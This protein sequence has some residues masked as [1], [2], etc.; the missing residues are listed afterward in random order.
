MGDSVGFCFAYDDESNGANTSAFGE[1]Q[2]PAGCLSQAFKGNA[3]LY[4][5]VR[6]LNQWDEAL[7][8]ILAKLRAIKTKPGP[9]DVCLT[10]PPFVFELDQVERIVERSLSPNAPGSPDNVRMLHGA[11]GMLGAF[12]NQLEARGRFGRDGGAVE[13]VIAEARGIQRDIQA[14]LASVA[15]QGAR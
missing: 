4:G 8:A 2:Y 9:P 1:V 10:C 3:A 13:R 5:D 15:R 14:V 6:K 11:I 12:I 7:Q